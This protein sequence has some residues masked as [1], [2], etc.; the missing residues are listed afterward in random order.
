M[1]NEFYLKRALNI[2][3]EYFVIISNIEEYENIAKNILSVIED[4]ISNLNSLKDQID[5]KKVSS[6]ESA[7]DS[8]LKIILELEDESN[9][10][11][12]VVDKMNRRIDSLKE[13]E[14]LLY[15]DLK[16][17]YPNASDDSIKKELHHYIEKNLKIKSRIKEE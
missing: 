13:E 5:M 8:L 7:K 1:I 16:K 2:R 3:K 11:E 17:E 6:V 15:S 10:V 12:S 4:K 9:K 14:S